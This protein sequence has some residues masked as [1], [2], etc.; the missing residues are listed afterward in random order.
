MTTRM[1]SLCDSC[2]HKGPSS[3]P[4]HRWP[5]NAFPSGV[6]VEIRDGSFDHRDPHPLDNGIT[7]DMDPDRQGILDLHL[8]IRDLMNLSGVR[9]EQPSEGE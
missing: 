2:V 9:D 6:P 5:C 8:E 1:P 7:Y 3:W 4:E